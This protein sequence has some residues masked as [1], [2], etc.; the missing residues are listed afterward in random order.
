MNRI[1]DE[2]YSNKSMRALQKE[3]YRTIKKYWIEHFGRDAVNDRK[4]I[5]SNSI[6]VKREL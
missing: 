6:C 5:S 2:F 3:Y 4:Y 1:I